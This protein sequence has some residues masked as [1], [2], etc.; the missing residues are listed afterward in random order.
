MGAE[1]AE[2]SRQSGLSTLA[3]ENVCIVC[4]LPQLS[5]ENSGDISRLEVRR[6]GLA[7]GKCVIRHEL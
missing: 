3:P 1:C 6:C 5:P 2:P 7:E 4:L